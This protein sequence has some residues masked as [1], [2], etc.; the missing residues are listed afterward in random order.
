MAFPGINDVFEKTIPKDA[1]FLYLLATDEEGNVS[2]N[3]FELTLPKEKQLSNTKI[4]T[5][6][7]KHSNREYS[8]T[9]ETELFAYGV[10]LTFDPMIYNP[11][12]AGTNIQ[13][14]IN[15]FELSDNYFNF[16]HDQKKT[17]VIKAPEGA[18]HIIVSAYNMEEDLKISL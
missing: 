11:G 18:E 10:T 13:K 6:L 14:R 2:Y 8:L 7:K 3:D 16:T 5:N 15:P 4:M 17:L 12:I 9:L 1:E